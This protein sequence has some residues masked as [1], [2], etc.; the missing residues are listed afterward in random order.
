MPVRRQPAMDGF[1]APLTG[2][3]GSDQSFRGIRQQGVPCGG[4]A[5]GLGTEGQQRL[6]VDP[7]TQCCQPAVAHQLRPQ[8]RAGTHTQGR[9]VAID[10]FR[11]CQPQDG[12]AEELQPLVVVLQPG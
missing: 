4:I 5:F 10:E 2:I 9:V 6:Q 11:G 7:T 12:I 3:E 1:Q 8:V